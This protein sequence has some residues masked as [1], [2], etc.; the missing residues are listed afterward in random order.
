[1]PSSPPSSPPAAKRQRVDLSATSNL[2]ESSSSNG[3][4]QKVNGNTAPANGVHTAAPAAS[5]APG[6]PQTAAEE[7]SDE[8]PE[9]VV[10]EEEDLGHRD[11]YLDTVSYI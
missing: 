5:S 8:E 11:M 6:L 3:T 4:P 7:E 10:A 9:E 1:M 2:A